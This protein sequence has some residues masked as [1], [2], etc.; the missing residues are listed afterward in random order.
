MSAAG[1]PGIHLVGLPDAA[2]HEAKDRVRAAVVNSGWHVAERADRAGAL[3]R[4]AA[5]GR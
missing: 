5:Q 4:D 3:A 1:C 2:L